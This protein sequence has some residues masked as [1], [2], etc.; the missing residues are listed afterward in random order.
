MPGWFSESRT[1]WR[2]YRANYKHTG[3]VLPSG[4][5][6][7]QALATFVRDRPTESIGGLKILEV[8]PGT[9]AVTRQI[10]AALRPADSLDLCELNTAFCEVLRQRLG[11]ERPFCDVAARVRIFHQPVEQ[12]ETQG[13]YD[14]VVSCLPLNNF[15]V[16]EV[17]AILG[18]LPR[19]LKPGGTLSFF[20]YIGIRKLR[21]VVADAADKKRLAGIGRAMDGVLTGEIRRDHVWVNVPPAYVHHVRFDCTAVGTKR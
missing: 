2:E 18:Q 21:A 5:R 7:G 3:A 15:Q 9:G 6:L 16:C 4:R 13:E 19:M 17:E 14:L 11:D 8:G 20:Q 1:F 12:L 10:C